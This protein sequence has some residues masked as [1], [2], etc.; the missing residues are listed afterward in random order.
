MVV[1]L[2]MAV[3]V[4]AFG[5][6]DTNEI[7]EF[8]VERARDLATR[9]GSLSLKVLPTLSPEVAEA[10]ALHKGLPLLDG[11]TTLSPE[12]AKA[13]AAHEGGLGLAARGKSHP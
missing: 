9:E 8:D 1:A 3:M 10:V 11:L 6:Q 4:P 13:L 2:V 5:Q 12:V 7:R